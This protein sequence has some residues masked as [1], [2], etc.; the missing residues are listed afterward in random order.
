M[1]KDYSC[2]SDYRSL[3]LL[4]GAEKSHLLYKSKL[5]KNIRNGGIINTSFIWNTI[6]QQTYIQN[7]ESR[8]FR[9]VKVHILK[10][11]AIKYIYII[12]ESPKGSPLGGGVL[13]NGQFGEISLF[14]NS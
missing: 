5:I 12:Q 9:M 10:I 3:I 6:N 8:F 13:K 4:G 14:S 11:H 1:N 7:I 2:D